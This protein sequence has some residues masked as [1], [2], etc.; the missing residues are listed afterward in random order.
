[1]IQVDTGLLI[2]YVEYNTKKIIITCTKETETVQRI[3][4]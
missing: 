1:M 4:I 3:Y 2:T